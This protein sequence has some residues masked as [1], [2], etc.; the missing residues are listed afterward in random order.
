MQCDLQFNIAFVVVAIMSTN[1][2]LDIG[3]DLA[4]FLGDWVT[5]QALPGRQSAFSASQLHLLQELFQAGI[6]GM[7]KII[8]VRLCEIEDRLI[9]LEEKSLV[10]HSEALCEERCDQ[11]IGVFVTDEDKILDQGEVALAEAATNPCSSKT[12]S[13]RLRRQ[14]AKAKY[15]YSRAALISLAPRSICSLVR[16]SNDSD[17]GCSKTFH[18][19]TSDCDEQQVYV[20]TMEVS[21]AGH[22]DVVFA[23]KPT[24]MVHCGIPAHVLQ[25]HCQSARFLQSWWRHVLARMKKQDDDTNDGEFWAT[26]NSYFAED[27]K[28]KPIERSWCIFED[29]SCEVTQITVG[30]AGHIGMESVAGGDDARGDQTPADSPLLGLSYL[31]V[32][33]GLCMRRVST[34]HGGLFTY[35]LDASAAHVL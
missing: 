33:D 29:L 10:K 8:A 3:S 11:H 14:R 21:S 2:W 18:V 27:D 31:S 13:R 4:G 35:L 26:I 25:G 22:H 23:E 6:T 17:G 16:P 12:R 5:G 32:R 9:K 20:Q 28:W 24:T 1:T 7:A 30:I 19:R 15:E 34:W